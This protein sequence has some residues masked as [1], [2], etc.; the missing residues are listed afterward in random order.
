[1]SPQLTIVEHQLSIIRQHHVETLA[2][3]SGIR[4]R[5]LGEISPGYLKRTA[6]SCSARKL[7][8][9]SL[10]SITDNLCQSKDEMLNTA[11]DFYS[12]L[13]SPTPVD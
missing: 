13:Y 2:L 11:A 7:I 4:W 12:N 1:M 6:T 3:R 10:N 8:P 5:E 9:P